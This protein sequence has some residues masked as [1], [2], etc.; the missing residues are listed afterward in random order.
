VSVLRRALGRPHEERSTGITLLPATG[1]RVPEP[2]PGYGMAGTGGWGTGMVWHPYTGTNMVVSQEAAFSL[3]PVFACIRLLSEAIATLPLQ[4]FTRSGGVRNPY[5]PVPDYL[6]FNPPLMSRVSYLSQ[7]MTSLLTDGN[8]F[9]AT[10]RDATGVVLAT[11]PLD[12]CRVTVKRDEKSKEIVYEVDSK[13][14]SSWD[15][16]HIPGMMLG[17]SLRG[18]S[19]LAA[20]REVTEGGLRS[21]DYYRH[22][23]RNLAVP[24]AVIK[25]PSAG[26]T[27]EAERAKAQRVADTWQQTHSGSN[28]GRIGVLVGGAELTSIAISPHDAEWLEAKRFSVSE[29]ARFYGVPPH[30]IADAS[31]STSWGSG[32]QEQN[33][34]FGQF[35][36]RPWVERIEDAHTRLLTTEGLTEVFIKLNVDALLRA[37][38]KDRYESYAVAIDNGFMTVNEARKFEDMPPVKWGDEPFIAAKQDKP[39]RVPIQQNPTV[40]P[41]AGNG[42]SKP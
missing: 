38:L 21:Q 32:L 37:S 9:V 12:P 39:E 24:P 25:V 42:G 34:A 15:I 4:T 23:L 11:I 1:R 40:V 28:V 33:L 6:L 5:Y 13:P 8:A 27:P 7:V 17:E 30:L 35:S 14:Y 18:V 2:A 20:A 26:G 10:I 3:S 41:D 19:P 31:N 29:V 16:L 22:F 36:L